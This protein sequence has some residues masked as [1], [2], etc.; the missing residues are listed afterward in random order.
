MLPEY[1]P[2]RARENALSDVIMTAFG[3][4]KEEP[5]IVKWADRESC[6][7]E[8]VAFMEN[9]SEPPENE[10]FA[11]FQLMLPTEAKKQFLNRFHELY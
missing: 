5:P 1:A 4:P 3:L 9:W 2:Y 7:Q 11:P 10:F 8:G 6:K